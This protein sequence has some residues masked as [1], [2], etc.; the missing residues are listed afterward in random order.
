MSALLS[1]A[2]AAAERGWPVFPLRPG[3]KRPALHPE[4]RCPRTGACADGHVTWERRATTDPERIRAA[5]TTGDWNIGLA[6]GPARLVVIDLDKPKNGTDAPDGA[7]NLLAL[8]ERA[9]HPV[10]TTRT[11]RTASGGAHLYFSAPD[12]S[13]LRNTAGTLGPLIDTRAHGGY[14]LAPG[15]VI[16]G[17][18][19]RA[20][21][22][23]LIRPL[24]DWL[25]ERLAPPHPRSDTD[26]APVVPLPRARSRLATV[27]LDRETAKA[28]QAAEGARNATLLASVRAV[29]R[30][31]AWGDLDRTHVETAFQGA[32][33]AAGLPAA[34][35]T[36]TI[37]SA[38]DWSIRTARPRNAA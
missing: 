5:W 25:L 8:C 36:A 31:V 35:V 17:R 4:T 27:V 14:V 10:P 30:F 38:L 32:G 13:H 28:R 9:G 37:R 16:N 34:E 3:G 22:P 21:G 20:E 2:L 26:P 1:A 24:P 6:T 7:A 33:E 18:T 23:A 12:G 11:V 29:G 19:Y 15:S